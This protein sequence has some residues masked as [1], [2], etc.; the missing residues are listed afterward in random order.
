MSVKFVVMNDT[1]T[2]SSGLVTMTIWP[3]VGALMVSVGVPPPLPL[4]LPLLLLPLLLLPLLLVLPPSVV[5]PPLSLLQAYEPRTAA[6]TAAL[7]ISCFIVAS[8]FGH[9]APCCAA[10]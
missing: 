6:S 8:G 4:L 5:P 2:L 10:R 1:G 9:G 3:A 7:P